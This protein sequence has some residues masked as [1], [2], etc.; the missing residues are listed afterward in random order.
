MQYISENN[1]E[2][3]SKGILTTDGVHLNTKGSKII[4]NE[5]IKFLN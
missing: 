3:K 4:A 1:P 5:M 2:N